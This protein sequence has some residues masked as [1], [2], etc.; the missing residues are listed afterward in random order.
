MRTVWRSTATR[1]G[2]RMHGIPCR[3]S[4]KT[5]SPTTAL[6]HC[7][8][9]FQSEGIRALGFIPLV[10][11]GRLLG[12][13]M[14][15]YARPHRFSVE[16]LR[17]AGTIA[18]HVGFG[19]ARA[20]AD[21]EVANALHRERVARAEADAARGQ[22]ERASQAKD[23]FLAMLA[24]ELRN[25]L[26]VIATALAV[27]E[28]TLPSDP[29]YSR[30]QAAIRRQTEHLARLLDDLLDVA[31]VTKGE[32]HLHRT[33]QDL[34]ATIEHGVENQRSFIE[35]KTQSLLL[36]IS[37]EPVVVMGDP[38][39]LQQVFGNILNN[40]AKYT[41]GVER[42]RSPWPRRMAQ[43]A[44]A[45]ATAVQVSPRTSSNGSLVCSRKQIRPWHGRKVVWVSD[46]RSQGSWWSFMAGG[47]M[48]PVKDLGMGRNSSLSCLSWSKKRF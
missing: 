39:R 25:P 13:F 3:S 28:S 26:G 48:R 29:R 24:H 10:Y 6:L 30:S 45:F 36:D 12:K 22:A 20:Q 33:P 40:A 7:A 9:Y 44:C 11:H 31:R 42:F 23:E 2:R 34:R 4:W 43:H 46:S 8:R 18:H 27:L 19:I 14:L 21:A 15:Y 47:C 38:V 1:R 5:S 16:E 17:L 41:P 37:N 35:Q 32:I